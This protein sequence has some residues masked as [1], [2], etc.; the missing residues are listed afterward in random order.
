MVEPD[1]VFSLGIYKQTQTQRNADDLFYCKS[2]NTRAIIFDDAPHLITPSLLDYLKAEHLK[3]TFFLVASN[4]FQPPPGLT[5]VVAQG[6]HH[7]HERIVAEIK[8]TKKAVRQLTGQRLKYVRPP[9]GDIDGRVRVVL[10]KLGYMVA[11]WTGGE[12]GTND[13]MLPNL[14]TEQDIVDYFEKSL[15]NYVDGG[16]NKGVISLEHD[17]DV[18]M[19]NLHK[20]LVPLGRARSIT[21]TDVTGCQKER[22]PYQRKRDD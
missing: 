13:W 17:R 4:I 7:P 12:F 6:P 10:K 3:A 16:R 1:W 19:G 20:K 22:F 8:W 5:H 9:Y 21:I 14:I 2:N 18:Y 15:D 11:V